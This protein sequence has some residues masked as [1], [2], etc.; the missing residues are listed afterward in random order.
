MRGNKLGQTIEELRKRGKHIPNELIIEM[1]RPVLLKEQKNK[2]I[3][4]NYP[5]NT[6]DVRIIN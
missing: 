3:L 2:Y 6:N 1:L 5:S 4:L